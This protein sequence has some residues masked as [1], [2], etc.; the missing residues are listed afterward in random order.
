VMPSFA[1]WVVAA[2]AVRT[3]ANIAP[4]AA[5][6]PTAFLSFCSAL[7]RVALISNLV[8]AHPMGNSV[9]ESVS[10]VTCSRGSTPMFS[11]CS[12][13]ILQMEQEIRS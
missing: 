4:T 10:T 5:T 2:R 8:A 3:D 1:R 11:E 6:N 12:G 9:A 13:R 7:V